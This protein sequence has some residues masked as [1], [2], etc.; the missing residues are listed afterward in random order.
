[1]THGTSQT[2]AQPS[3]GEPGYDHTQ[4]SWY[5]KP[6]ADMTDDEVNEARAYYDSVGSQ[7]MEGEWLKRHGLPWDYGL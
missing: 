6:G 4:A 3:P 2:Q 5:S 7:S 1:M